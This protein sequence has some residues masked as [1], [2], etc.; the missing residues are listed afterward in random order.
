M[1]LPTSNANWQRAIRGRESHLHRAG[2]VALGLLVAARGFLV[3]FEV[4]LADLLVFRRSGNSVRCV[5]GQHDLRVHTVRPNV[6]RDFDNGCASCI[7][8]VPDDGARAAVRRRLRQ[9]FPRVVWTRVGILTHAE[10]CRQLLKQPVHTL[11]ALSTTLGVSHDAWRPLLQTKP[12]NP[13]ER[14]QHAKVN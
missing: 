1:N 4:M 11:A 12:R 13:K 9:D 5:C 3:L 2:K 14:T 6:R 7:I 8:L 10:C